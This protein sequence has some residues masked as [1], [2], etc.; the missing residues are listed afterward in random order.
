M[1][2]G[3]VGRSSVHSLS[4]FSL[5]AVATR[6][7]SCWLLRMQRTLLPTAISS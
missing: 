1:N 4:V 5:P 2:I 6:C 3:D 7:R